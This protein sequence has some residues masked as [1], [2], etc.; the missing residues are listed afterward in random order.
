MTM[1]ERQGDRELT[2]DLTPIKLC[3]VC[4]GLTLKDLI[5]KTHRAVEQVGKDPRSK[6]RKYGMGDLQLNLEAGVMFK[7]HD[8]ILQMR[9]SSS[10][11]DLCAEIWRCFEDN[12][13]LSS[14]L[15]QAVRLIFHRCETT[16]IAMGHG[17]AEN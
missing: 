1:E 17:G 14:G 13:G 10:S 6:K 5:L 4:R 7:E 2:E 15:L 16:C 3:P 9:G 12:G 11:C 8:N